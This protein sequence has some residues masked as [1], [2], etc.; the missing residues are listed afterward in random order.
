MSGQT[1]I[2]KKTQTLLTKL[3]SKE[4]KTVLQTIKILEGEGNEHVIKPMFDLYKTT[5]SEKVKMALEDFFNKLSDS[6]S[7]LPMVELMRNEDNPTYRKMLIG[8]CWQSKVDFTPY[9]ADF[10]AMATSGDFFE[11]FECLTVIEN[12]DGPFEETQILEA[13]LYLKEYL[14]KDKGKVEQRD[15]MISEIALLLKGFDADID[16]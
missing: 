4:E 2:P 11:A 7:M 6:S 8:A 13:Q 3:E 16:A 15:Q 10:V 14:E 5:S 1:N 9:L 12:L